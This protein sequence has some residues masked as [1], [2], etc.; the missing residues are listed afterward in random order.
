MKEYACISDCMHSGN[1]TCTVLDLPGEP[2][3]GTPSTSI[4][5]C[6]NPPY[7][8]TELNLLNIRGPMNIAFYFELF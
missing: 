6:R 7:V 3:T 8:A 1:A 5:Y 2:V 4:L